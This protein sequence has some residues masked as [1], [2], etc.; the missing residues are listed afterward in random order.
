MYLATTLDSLSTNGTKDEWKRFSSLPDG[1]TIDS[2]SNVHMFPYHG[3]FCISFETAIWRKRHRDNADP[4][5]KKAVG[6]WPKMYDDKWEKIGESTLPFA[7]LRSIVPFAVISADRKNIGFHLVILPKDG[8]MRFLST[9]EIGATNSWSILSYTQNKDDPPQPSWSRIAYWNSTIVAV[10]DKS[11][12]WSLQVDFQNGTYTISDKI[13]LRPTTEFTATDLGPVAVQEDG[14]LY[15]RLTKD[16]KDGK[17]PVLQWTRWVLQDGVTNLGVAAPSVLLNLQTLTSTL[18]SRYIETQTAMYPIIN[19]II[20]FALTHDIYLDLLLHAAKDWEDAL[21]DKKRAGAIK[22]GKRFVKHAKV[23][24]KILTSSI[25]N[26]KDTVNIMTSELHD[27]NVQLQFQLQLLRDKLIGLQ[28]TLK[29]Q[30]EALRKLKAT[31]WGAIAALFLGMAFAVPALLSG[32]EGMMVVSAGALFIGGLV[33]MIALS[34]KMKDLYS[35]IADTQAQIKVVNTAVSQ[36]S[37]VLSNFTDLDSMYS[38]LNV[39]WGRMA[40][41][42]N[43]LSTMDNTMAMQLGTELLADPSSIITA[44]RV[45]GRWIMPQ[46]NT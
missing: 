18:K 2:S 46:H 40:N 1:V 23:W 34:F 26:T 9:D 31:F 44:K 16:P 21:D 39:F 13:T 4:F 17:D 27:V 6:D 7:D 11:N 36:I 15:K 35:S 10:D 45:M 33:S 3:D 14:Y 38:T 43:S 20:V 42:A 41:N 32:V 19:K 22:E 29:V 24:A 5:L 28:S 30:K 37:S 12:I 25:S 8:P